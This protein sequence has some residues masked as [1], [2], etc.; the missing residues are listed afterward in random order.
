MPTV[1]RQN[2]YRIGFFSADGDEPAHV[3]VSKAS[4]QAKFWLQPVGL[5]DN[6]GFR[7]HELREIETILT[8]NQTNLLQAWHEYFG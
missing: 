7:R 3:H 5:S 1:L 6:L 8:E 4:A 2:G